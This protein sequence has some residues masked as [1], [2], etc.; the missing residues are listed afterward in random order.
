MST[1]LVTG[2]SNRPGA[3]YNPGLAGGAMMSAWRVVV[4]AVGVIA[5]AIVGP[6]VGSA[7][8]QQR[9]KYLG[10][11]Q[12]TN[13]HDHDEEKLWY[14]KKEIPEVHRL[15]PDQNNAGHINSLKQLEAKKSDDYAKAIGL[16]DKYDPA[17][18]C[19]ACHATVFNGE[20]N[21]GV[22]CES[23]HGPGSGYRDPHQTKDS[24]ERSVKEFGM[25]RLI[26]NFAGWTQQCTNC[27]VMTDDKLIAAG[28]PSG[29]D[30]D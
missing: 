10:P 22:S 19:V 3:T 21:A 27:H 20:A 16:A 9:F 13:C 2:G 24:Y 25:T 7:A 14:E 28:H 29:D 6:A 26:G 12:C 8:A 5:A 23:C 17:G 4:V 1:V 15:F 18:T 30:F 11:K